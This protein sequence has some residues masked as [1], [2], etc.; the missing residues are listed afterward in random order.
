MTKDWRNDATAA[1]AAA[2]A[3]DEKDDDDNTRYGRVGRPIWAITTNKMSIRFFQRFFILK[4]SDTR[5]FCVNQQQQ[6]AAASLLLWAHAGSGIG[7]RTDGR[8]DDRYIDPAPHSMRPMSLAFVHSYICSARG[9]CVIYSM[10]SGVLGRPI[11][12]YTPYTNLGVF[13]DS[14]CSPQ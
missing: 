7:R 12:G 5:S 8:T 2:A 9:C 6:T 4:T 10:G 11:R 14:V 3:V 1:A 13:L